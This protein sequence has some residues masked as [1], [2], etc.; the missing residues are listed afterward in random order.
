MEP[1]LIVVFCAYGIFRAYLDYMHC[2]S[3]DGIDQ[4]LREINDSLYSL[5]ARI[6]SM[7]IEKSDSDG[8]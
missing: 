3:I 4:Q 7:H 6:R 2:E 8:K 5:R 1:F